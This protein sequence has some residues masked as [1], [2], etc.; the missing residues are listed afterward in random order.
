MNSTCG[1]LVTYHPNHTVIDHVRCLSQQVDEV[2]VVDNGSGQQFEPILS[3]LRD[4]P[5]VK[6]FINAENMGIA[7]A[8]NQGLELALKHN[9]DWVVTFDQDSRIPPDYLQGLGAVLQ[10]CPCQDIVAIVAPFFL[11]KQKQ[12]NDPHNSI[13]RYQTIDV[14]M[15]SGNLLRTA[16]VRQTG[17]M[18]DGYFIDYVDFEFCLRLR[19]CGWRIIQATQVNLPHNL[20]TREDHQFLGR[21]FSLIAHNSLRRYYNSRNRLITYGRHGWRFPAWLVKDLAWWVIEIG[22][23]IVF[24]SHKSAKLKSFVWGVRDG[25]AGRLGPAPARVQT[26]FHQTRTQL[27]NRPPKPS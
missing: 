22:K 25:L 19:R 23:I 4:I 1:I 2:I 24:E 26:W 13:I 14:A 6:V 8:F 20:G 5:G 12:K 21:K 27:N 17:L 9:H 7:K 11:L 16:A 3:K 18:D 10:S 15:A